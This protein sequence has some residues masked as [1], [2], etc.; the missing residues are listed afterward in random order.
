MNLQ[1]IGGLAALAILQ[2]SSFASGGSYVILGSVVRSASCNGSST[3]AITS[4][5]IGAQD[6]DCTIDTMETV[7][8]GLA[9]V[10]DES[11][12]GGQKLTCEQAHVV[13]S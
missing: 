6:F 7:L 5:T 1:L 3:G 8:G 4:T 11:G 9:L 12:I 13:A 10:V 2:S